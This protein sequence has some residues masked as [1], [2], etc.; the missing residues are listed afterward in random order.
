MDKK[1]Y[2]KWTNSDRDWLREL[3]T[4]HGSDEAIAKIMDRNPTAVGFQRSKLRIRLR[5]S[6]QGCYPRSAINTY[7]PHRAESE[8]L[9]E[10]L[11]SLSRIVIPR[12]S[13]SD[14]EFIRESVGVEE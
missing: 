10:K 11:M 12:F 7:K 3:A 2:R 1:L 9:V 6:V 13:I 4:L 14:V 5:G 8:F